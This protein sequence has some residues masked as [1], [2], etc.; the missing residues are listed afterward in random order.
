MDKLSNE[1]G[2]QACFYI[3]WKVEST[4][5][6]NTDSILKQCC[7]GINSERVRVGIIVLYRWRPRARYNILYSTNTNFDRLKPQNTFDE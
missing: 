1:L 6:G 2:Y 4:W 3:Q 7:I 5:K